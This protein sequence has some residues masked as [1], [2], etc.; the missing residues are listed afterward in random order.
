MKLFNAIAAAAAVVTASS[1][2]S[3]PVQASAPPHCDEA[4]K[5]GYR[6]TCYAGNGDL[7]PDYFR[8]KEGWAP[9][10]KGNSSFK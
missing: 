4:A 1:H 2:V 3:M 7:Y 6:G 5:K 8:Y 10:N 9:T